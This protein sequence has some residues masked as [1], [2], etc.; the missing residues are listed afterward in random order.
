MRERIGKSSRILT[1]SNSV[2][3]PPYPAAAA[4]GSSRPSSARMPS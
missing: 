1:T 3:D 2:I 4:D